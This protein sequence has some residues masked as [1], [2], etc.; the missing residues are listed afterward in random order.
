MGTK[1]MLCGIIDS[2]RQEQR[3]VISKNREARIADFKKKL[4]SQIIAKHPGNLR[5]ATKWTTFVDSF[6]FQNLTEEKLNRELNKMLDC[7]KEAE[8]INAKDIDGYA[9]YGK[10]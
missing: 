3:D 5:F 4:K 2:L 7:D 10:A 1:E 9:K 8:K 6:N